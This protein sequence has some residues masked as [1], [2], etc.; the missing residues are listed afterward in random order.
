[1]RLHCWLLFFYSDD[2]INFS[3]NVVPIEVFFGGW[4]VLCFLLFLLGFNLLFFL[5]LRFFLKLFFA[6]LNEGVDLLLDALEFIIVRFFVNHLEVLLQFFNFWSVRSD[7]LTLFAEVVKLLAQCSRVFPCKVALVHFFLHK[8][9]VFHR[10]RYQILQLHFHGYHFSHTK[11]PC[12]DTLVFISLN[13]LNLIIKLREW[14]LV[15]L[16][17]V[18][19]R[20]SWSMRA[21]NRQAMTNIWWS[22]KWNYDCCHY[23]IKILHFY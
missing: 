5:H 11:L 6:C 14:V 18:D 15:R 1:M 13:L 12:H 17:I 16:R 3:G 9:D 19:I 21:V 20:S 7:V 10:F 4:R 22:H 8:L 2:F 23:R